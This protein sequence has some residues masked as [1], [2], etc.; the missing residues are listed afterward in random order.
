MAVISIRHQA[1]FETTRRLVSQLVNERL[2]PAALE[3][4]SP[5]ERSYLCIQSPIT[6]HGPASGR[7][8]KISIKP[9]TNITLKGGSVISWIRP[10]SLE[11]NLVLCDKSEE[12]FELS[13]RA[14]FLFIL[15]WLENKT[16]SAALQRVQLELELAAMFQGI[17][18]LRYQK[19]LS[20]PNVVICRTMARAE[21]RLQARP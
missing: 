6:Y 14:V 11:P 20:H 1:Q 16:N 8:L 19:R 9:E 17:S 3:K 12:I 7:R 10:Q 21:H 15:P 18:H 4:T 13:P 2:A 5:T